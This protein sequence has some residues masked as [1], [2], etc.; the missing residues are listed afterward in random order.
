MSNELDL[1]KQRIGDR[2]HALETTVSAWIAT[3]ELKQKQ[4]NIMIDKLTNII[5]G[6][7]SIGISEKVRNAEKELETIRVSHEKR[8]KN[9]WLVW[10][11]LLPVI[12]ERVWSHVIGK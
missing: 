10:V 9:I 5:V 6:N 2:L 8:Q 3:S 1:E 12:V 7:G 11:G 4:D